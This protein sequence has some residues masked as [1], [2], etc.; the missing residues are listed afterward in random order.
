V[1]FEGENKEE[2]CRRRSCAVDC[3]VRAELAMCL[4]RRCA[5]SL[6][7]EVAVIAVCDCRESE[8]GGSSDSCL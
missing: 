5:E 6:N 7:V 3:K 8:C 4:E 1:N 2:I